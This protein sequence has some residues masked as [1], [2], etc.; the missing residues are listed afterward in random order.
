MIIS[1]GNNKLNSN[2][3]LPNMS[4]TITSW[5]Q[6]ISFEVIETI[7]QGID[8]V[9]GS[10]T[11]INTR[12][13]VQAPRDKDLEILPIGTW[14]FEWLLIHCLPDVELNNNQYII[15]N[16]KKYKVMAKKDFTAYG[17]VR[18]TVL[19]AYKADTL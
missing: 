16:D 3:T 4:N 15:Y 13:V 12:G 8:R 9:E 2:S 10:K 14:N 1:A 11:T 6:N 5:F 17:Y 7:R 19:E 18:Y